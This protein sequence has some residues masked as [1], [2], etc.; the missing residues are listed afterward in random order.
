MRH[1]TKILVDDYIAYPHVFFHRHQ[2]SNA[3]YFITYHIVILIMTANQNNRQN[4]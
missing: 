2:V 1:W 4:Y 3:L